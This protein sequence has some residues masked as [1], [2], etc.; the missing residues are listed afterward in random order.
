MIAPGQ[1]DFGY[2]AFAVGG[3]ASLVGALFRLLLEWSDRFRDAFINWAHG[4]GFDGFALPRSAKP[5]VVFM[6]LLNISASF[7]VSEEE[8]TRKPLEDFWRTDKIGT[9]L[10]AQTRSPI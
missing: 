2:L 7:S 5:L 1:V 8:R 9:A 4:K 10:R 3:I 6:S